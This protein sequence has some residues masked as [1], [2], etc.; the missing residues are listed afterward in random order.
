MSAAANKQLLQAVFDELAK[1]NG[2]PFLDALADDVRW[3]LTGSTKWSRTYEGKQAVRSE[4]LGPIFA[5]FADTYTNRAVRMIAEDD[6]VVVECRGNVTTKA[7][8]PYNNSYC[9]VCRVQDGKV[10]E[11]TEYMDTQL[12]EKALS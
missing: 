1:G 4:L 5:Q 10:R 7:G 8:V 11:I 2:R 12:A 6:L 3:T 9:W